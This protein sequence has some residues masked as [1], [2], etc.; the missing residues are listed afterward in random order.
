MAY[1]FFAAEGYGIGD[2]LLDKESIGLAKDLMEEAKARGVKLL[3]PVDTVVAK[4]F[5]ADAEHKTVK[6]DA[7][8]DGWQGLDIG[9]ETQKLFA[10]EIEAAKTVI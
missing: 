3:L 4:E 7:I 5:A 6:A 9:E 2:S 8:P 1:T 10:A